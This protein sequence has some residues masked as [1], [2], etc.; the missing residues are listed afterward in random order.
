MSESKYVNITKDPPKPPYLEIE[1]NSIEFTDANGNRKIDANESATI[2]FK[3]V[4]SGLGPGIGM[5]VITRKPP[6]YRPEF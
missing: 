5:K 6:E 1:Q 3:L 2:S 4:N